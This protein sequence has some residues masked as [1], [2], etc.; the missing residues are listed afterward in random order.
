MRQGSHTRRRGMQGAGPPG[1]AAGAMLVAAL[2]TAW[3]FRADFGLGP[4]A[5]DTTTQVT[6][7]HSAHTATPVDAT[8]AA[9]SGPVTELDKQLLVKVRQA[10][11][12]ELP[13]GRLAQENGSMEQ[14][15]RAGMH[16]MEGH[17]RLDQM[18]R[19]I[20]A[21]LKVPIPD[22]P[23]ADQQSWLD[24]LE[25]SKGSEFDQFFANQLRDSH[26]K[27]FVVI[28][29]VRATTQN[30]VIRDLAIEADRTVADHMEV[31]EDTGLVKPQTFDSVAADVLP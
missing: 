3:V 25:S 10:D 1:V 27:V 4:A 2:A 17:S 8:L 20:A 21:A 12:W 23:T 11:L 31:M 19:E 16:L 18:V 24:R 6:T 30:S 7:D 9:S 5:A 29:K 28:A 13:A 14:V 26:G 22:K 15:K